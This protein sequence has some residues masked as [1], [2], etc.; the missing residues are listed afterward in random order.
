VDLILLFTP[1]FMFYL[2][3]RQRVG[4][5]AATTVVVADRQDDLAGPDA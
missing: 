5:M 1:I 2:P 3:L 4:D